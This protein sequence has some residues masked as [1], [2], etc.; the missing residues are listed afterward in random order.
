VDGANGVN[1]EVFNQVF[2]QC[3]RI[4]DPVEELVSKNYTRE[5]Y[6]PTENSQSIKSD[7]GSLS[8][9][10]GTCDN[11]IKGAVCFVRNNL[12]CVLEDL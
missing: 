12:G 5:V 9:K 3:L 4:L 6:P 11:I 8:L 1:S 7:Q 2:F 10:G